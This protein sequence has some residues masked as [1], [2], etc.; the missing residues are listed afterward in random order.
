[1]S[2]GDIVLANNKTNWISQ[3]IKWF[4]GSRFSHSFVTMPDILD[5]PMCMEASEG[6]VDMAR[7]DTKYLDNQNEGIEVWSINVSQDAK[8]TAIKYILSDLEIGYGFLQYPWFMWRRIC[9][10]FGKDIRSQNNWNSDGMICSQLC[11]TYLRALGLSKVL[12]GYGSGSIAPQ[13]LQDIF[14]AHPDKF[15]LASSSRL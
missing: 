14:K 6:G 15:T 12:E 9:L 10:I 8:D 11:V 4:T 2:Y 7:F 5:I 3:C 13:D 1:M